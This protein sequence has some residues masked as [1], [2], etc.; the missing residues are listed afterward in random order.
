MNSTKESTTMAHDFQVRHEQDLPVPPDHAWKALTTYDG[1]VGW[2]YPMEVEPRVGGTVSRGPSTV[3]EW[4]PPHRFICRYADD[5]GFSNTLTYLVD[6]REG[7]T[8]HLRM[9]IHWVHEGTPDENWGTKTDA[10]EKHVHFYQHGL[11]QYLA[12][13]DGRTAAYVRAMHGEPT[14][15]PGQF[16]TLQRHLGLADG[17]AAGD[18]VRLT[19]DAELG[20]PQDAV[21]DYLDGDFLGLRTDDA[22]YRIF[23]GSTWNW[24]VWAGLHLFRDGVDKERTARAWR[25]WLDRAVT[26][27]A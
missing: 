2:L 8:S 24:P 4:E 18:T 1:N 5:T 27:S 11:S 23:N 12:H 19:L 25:A 10:A 13:F 21:V 14:S 20:G 22:L 16:A 3:L 6:E 17:T 7:G 26:P 9:S 15:D